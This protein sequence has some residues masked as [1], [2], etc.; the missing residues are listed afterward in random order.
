MTDTET[1]TSFE[2]I[3][4]ELATLR[5]EFDRLLGQ[6][7]DAELQLKDVRSERDQQHL[8]AAALK[9]E[10]DQQHR[11]AGALKAALDHSASIEQAIGII[12]EK[13]GV[14]IP[15]AR[16]RL[17]GYSRAHDKQIRAVAA[18]IV[19]AQD[20]KSSTH[21]TTEAAR[22]ITEAAPFGVPFAFWNALTLAGAIFE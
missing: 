8:L 19:A 12:A 11:L 13:A 14:G 18:S 1:V 16:A 15:E 7:A 3:A 10:R 5:N 17:K 9:T 2:R 4:G 21:D 20:P 22:V 6:L